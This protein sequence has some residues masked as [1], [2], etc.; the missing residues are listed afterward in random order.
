MF[1][2]FKAKILPFPGLEI[3]TEEQNLYV[4]F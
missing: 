1:L 3:I 4:G 2:H